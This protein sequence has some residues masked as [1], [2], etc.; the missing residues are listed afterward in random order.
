MVRIE[1]IVLKT[2]ISVQGSITA[3]CRNLLLHSK[4]CFELFGFDILIDSDLKPWLL[5]VNLSPSLV[6]FDL[7]IIKC[8]QEF[9]VLLLC[10]S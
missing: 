4:C 1:S 3:R 8:S 9:V 6:W 5:E 2:L 10:S 7:C